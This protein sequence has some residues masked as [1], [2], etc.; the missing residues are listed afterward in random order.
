MEL[1]PSGADTA[2]SPRRRRRPE[3][4]PRSGPNL[5]AI[6]SGNLGLVYFPQMPGR[7]TVEQLAAAH[8]GLVDAL[9]AVTRASGR[10]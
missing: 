5:I 1:G 2:T 4:P 3:T 8:P 10:C 9:A 6:A 7:V